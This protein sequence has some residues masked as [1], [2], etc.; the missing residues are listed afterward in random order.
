MSNLIPGNQK[1]LTMENRIFIETSLDKAM[2]FKE[3]AKYLCKDPSTISKEV[4]KHR[5]QKPRNEFNSPNRC[6][7]RI[8]CNRYNVCNRTISCKKKCKHCNACNARCDQFEEEICHT[9]Q[10]APYVCNACYKKAQCRQEKYFY[11]A[12]TANRQYRTIL[13]ESRVGINISET[14]LIALDE[15]V[16]PLVKQ[17]QSPY[18]IV[19]E[20]PEIGCSVKTIYNYIQSGALSIKNIDLPRKVRYKL[21]KTHKSGIKDTGIFE[22]RTYKDFQTL[23]LEHP[24]SNIVEMDTVYGCAGSHKVFLTFYFRSC[25]CMLIYLLADKTTE[26]VKK[27]FDTLERRLT[28]LGFCS[29]FPV[30]LTDRGMEFSNPDALETGMDG[31]IRTSIYYCD[32][33][34]SWQK[35]GIEK[36]HEY[37]RYV[38]PKGTSFDELTQYEATKLANHIN[39]AAR[40]SLNGSNPFKLA[41]ILLGQEAIKAFNLRE[42]PS[43]HINLTPALL[44]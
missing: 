8:Y 40:A 14:D 3:I 42:I 25:K 39:S 34:A 5:S 41:T 7:K 21:R 44:K 15:L 22:G 29:T 18:L 11:K 43:D 1:H 2:P 33:M 27:A 32:P 12:I 10:K 24:D 30:I 19:A 28:T 13:K 26:S 35:G 4:R 17:G 31:L 36:N 6:A 38:L 23:M 20:H 16:T 37:I 9:V